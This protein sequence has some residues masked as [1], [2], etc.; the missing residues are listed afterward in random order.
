[1]RSRSRGL[2]RFAG[3]FLHAVGT[4]TTRTLAASVARERLEEVRADP[5]YPLPATWAGT[6][7]GFPDYPNMSRITR[8]TRVTGAAPVRDYTIVS[9]KVTE[10]TMMRPGA[11]ALDTVNVTAV[12]ARP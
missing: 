1:L 12:V 8:V 4:S 3:E 6:A 9:V 10:P 11:M 7:I 5:T 2:A